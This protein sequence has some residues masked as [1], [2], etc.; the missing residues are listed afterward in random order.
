MVNYLGKVILNLAEVTSP[1][2]VLLKNNFDYVSS[3]L[4]IFDRNLP[5]KSKIDASSKGFG[6]L[7]KQSHGLL[8]NPKWHPIAYSSLVLQDYEKR[9]AKIEKEISTDFRVERFHK[10]L[11]G[12]KFTIINDLQLLKSIFSRSIVTCLPRI[13]K[14][15]LRLQKYDFKLEYASVKQC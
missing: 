3:L 15:F 5:S 6:A 14:I 2:L 1:L 7:A 11:Y 10:Y 4:K 9:Y 12:R 8:K 13:Q